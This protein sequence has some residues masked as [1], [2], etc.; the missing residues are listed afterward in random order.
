MWALAGVASP[1]AR[2]ATPLKSADE[3]EKLYLSLQRLTEN[4][5][6]D[7]VDNEDGTFTIPAGYY[8]EDILFEISK[9]ENG[10]LA[11]LMVNSLPMFLRVLHLPYFFLSILK[12]QF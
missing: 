4:T 9:S 11:L 10:Y 8:S 1:I 7:I 3:K 6:E 12:L 5:I 2:G